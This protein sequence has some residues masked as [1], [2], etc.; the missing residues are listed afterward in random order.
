MHVG[1]SIG[2]YDVLSAAV[3]PNIGFASPEFNSAMKNS[4]EGFRYVTGSDSSYTPFILPGSG[5]VAMESVMSFMPRG[6]R[7]LVVSNGVFGDRWEAI[8]SRY[9]VILKVLRAEAGKAVSTGDIE[10]E[11]SSGSYFAVAMTQVE[12]STGVRLDVESVAKAVRNHVDLVI[13]DGVASIGGETMKAAQWGIDVC[14]TASQKA[15]GAQAG[16]GLLVASP[17]AMEKL[18]G[19]SI[20]GYFADLRNW[21]DIMNKFLAGGGGYFATPPIGTV[22]SIQKSMDL[23]RSETMEARV[24]R[25][26][27]CS[28][29]F[30]AGI[31]HL[32]LEILAS[33]KLRSN[34]VSGVMVDGIWVQGDWALRD[35][36]GYY[37]LFGRSDDVIKVSG[38]RLGPNEIENAVMEVP[39]VVESAVIGVP[40]AMKG[41][42]VVIFYTG[43]NSDGTMDAIRK[44]VEESMGKSFLPR[45]TIWLPQLPKTRNG[46]IVRRVVKRAFLGQDPGDVSNLE[47]TAIMDYIKEVGR[48][49]DRPDDFGGMS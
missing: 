9:P 32:G 39:G 12:T 34:T 38:K 49:R 45:F 22:F 11:V 2:N 24:R 1:P 10:H 18:K 33:E 31:N 7:I 26:E 16:A 29:A 21:S 30:R 41:E 37:F 5:T 3:Q 6:S 47:D 4:L 28:Q 13:V 17:S 35:R 19:E 20:S 48:I 46:K 15:L 25:H 23:I 42:A 43:E 14:L 36:N 8:M 44:K 27:I 40:D